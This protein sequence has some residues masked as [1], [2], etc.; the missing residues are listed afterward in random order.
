MGSNVR[1]IQGVIR[2]PA[3]NNS[4]HLWVVYDERSSD[5]GNQARKSN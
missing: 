2:N 3:K 5:Y 1:S 4:N